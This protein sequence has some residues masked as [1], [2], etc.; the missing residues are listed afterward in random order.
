MTYLMVFIGGGIGSLCRYGLDRW[1]NPGLES[2]QMPWGT[3]AANVLACLVLG[4]GFALLLENKLT[5][6]WRLLALTG[7][8]GGFSTFSTFSL[9]LMEI[10]SGTDRLGLSLL[11]LFLSLAGGI[12]AIWVGR[13]V[14]A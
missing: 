8:C 9:E 11:Y 4:V 5:E 7:F 14:I 1:L 13:S 2:G 10:G 6:E 3:L 12:L